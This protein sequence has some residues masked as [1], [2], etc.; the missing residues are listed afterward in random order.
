[1]RAACSLS[2]VSGYG[3]YTSFQSWMR[4]DTLRVGCFFRWISMNPVTLPTD[5]RSRQL[6]ERGLPPCRRGLRLGPQ[7]AL[8]IARHDLDKNGS[9][10]VEVLQDA[11][12]ER[13]AR[14]L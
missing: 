1:Q 6:E 2:A 7:H 8:E 14:V 4:S 10:R 12:S 9:E 3:R 13:A 11:R 5:T